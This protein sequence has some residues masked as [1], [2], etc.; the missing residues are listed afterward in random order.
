MIQASPVEGEQVRA[1]E[2]ARRSNPEVARA[3]EESESTYAGLGGKAAESLVN[4][5]DPNL[6]DEPAGG[7]PTLPE[8]NQI[9][10]FPT[11]FAMSVAGSGGSRE[12][13]E[14]LEP[15]AF[16]ATPG[17]RTAIDLGLSEV[18]G[19]Y[20]PKAGLA[21]VRI[22]KRLNEGAALSEAGVSLTPVDEQGVA[23]AGEGVLDGASVFYGDTEDAS[24]GIMDVDTLVKPSTFGL[25]METILRSQR[26]PSRLFFKVGL[27]EEA[28]LEQESAGSGPVHVVDNGRTLAVIFAPSARDA[29]GT[30]V[31]VSMVVDGD[32]LVLTVDHPAGAYAYPI[33]VDP[34]YEYYAS[35]FTWDKQVN[36]SGSHATNWHFE[37]EGSL[38][39]GSE[40]SSGQG[41]IMHIAGNH[42]EHERGWMAYTTNG[43]SH[44]W[45]FASET[46]QRESE[47]RVESRVELDNKSGVESEQV[48]SNEVNEP[49]VNTPPYCRMGAKCGV[50]PEYNNSAAYVALAS[51]A[52]TGNAGENVFHSA[53]VAVQQ[54]VNPEVSFDTTDATVDGHPNAL[55][56]TKTWLG[57]H[58]NA[59]VKFTASEKGIGIEGWSSEHTNSKGGWEHLSEKSMLT[60][61]LCSG[62]QCPSEETEYIGYTS[63][64][65]DGEP[66]LGLDAWNAMYDSH[67]K[68][69]ESESLRH[70]VVK[71]DS[72]PPHSLVLTGLLAGNEIGAGE[73]HLK[74]E[75]TDGSGTTP[76]SGV[77]SIALQIDGKEVKSPSGF[78]EPGPCTAKSAEWTIIGR[79]YA[80]GR[81]TLALIATDNA[82]NVA[83][84]EDITMTVR[85]A[86][87][88]SLG[89]GSVNLESGE[90]TLGATDVSMG[91]LT[92]SR[93]YG[94]RHL[95]AGAEGP[96]G[97][98][99]AIS[100]TGQERLEKQA[101]ESVIFTN[102][103]GA[104]DIFRSKSK[105]VFEA[106]PGDS[107]L[108]LTESESEGAKTY[109]LANAASDTKTV[110]TLPEGGG[111]AWMPKIQEGP[112]PTD[113]VTYTFKTETEEG[114]KIT[115]PV[116]ALAPVPANVS[117]SPTLK[118]GCR[119]LEFIYG[120]ETKATGENESEW[121]EYKGRLKEV[122]FVA[123]NPATKK[124]EPK[125]VAAYAY[126]KQGRLR[127]EWD[128]RLEHP[129][130]VVYGYDAE[131][132]VTALTPPGQESWALI[133]GTIAGDSTA[134]RLLKV[135]QAPASAGLWDGEPPKNT[136]APKLTGTA[137]PSARMTV[138]N[139]TWSNA[140]V[141]YGYQWEDCNSAGN[142][143][144]PVLG[145]T[146]ANY[147]VASSDVGHRL[148]AQVTGANGGGSVVAATAASLE[149]KAAGIE[150]TEYPLAKETEPK[151]IA[152]GPDGNLWIAQAKST[153]PTVSKMTT[154]GKVTEYKLTSPFECPEY[155][156]A[157]PA[158]EAALWF[159]DNC[160][161]QIGK[162]T[163]SGTVK[164]Y[165]FTAGVG[166]QAITAGPDGNLWFTMTGV[167][168][169]GKITPAGT[170]SEYSAPSGSEP[171]VIAAG[172]EKES[173][174][175]FTDFKTSKIGK[176]TTSG[177]ITEYSLP[178]GS[179]PYGITAGPENEKA[180]WF[181]DWGTSK[182][183][184]ITTSGTITEYPIPS[185]S[186]SR[187][188]AVGPEGEKALWF[189]DA[190]TSKIGRITTSG[191]VTED[192][193]PSESRPQKI[194]AGPEKEQ[195]VWFSEEGPSKV[196]KVT[197]GPSTE[198]EQQTPRPGST[199]EYNV[200]LSGSG[201]PTMTK[202]EVEKWGQADD[203]AEATA[204]FPPDE[205]QGWPASGYKR[206]TIYY[207]D[208]KGRTVNVRSPS[209]GISTSEYNENNDAV[210]SLTPDN[211]AAALAEGSK[212][213]EVAKLL[214][215]ESKY[216][217]ET[218][219][220][221]EKEEKEP[222]SAAG[223]RL[224]E[225]LGPRHA[226]RLPHGKT[227]ENEEV[228]ARNHTVYYY[229]EGAPSE[230]GP[231]RLVTKV[232]QGAQVNG[233]ADR[234][235][236]TTTDSYS[237]QEGLGWKLRAPT[238]VTG[239]PSGLKVTHTTVYE[240]S[241]GNV[242]ETRAPAS[243]GEGN[244]HDTR[245]IYYTAAEN[246]S[247]PGCGEQPQWAEMPCETLPGKQPEPAVPVITTTYNMWGE[248]EKITRTVGAVTRT[249]TVE[250][251]GAGRPLASEAI[252]SEGKALPKVK[253]EYNAETGALEKQS[254]TTEGETKTITSKDNAR[255]QLV[256]YTDADGNTTEYEYELEK[257]GRL[258]RVNDGKGTQ[259][260]TYEETTGAVSKLVDTQG[261]NVLTFTAAYDVEG[262]MAS[263]GYPNGMTASDSR[264][265][266][267]ETTGLT[268]E[269]KTHCTEKCVWFTESVTPSIHDQTLEQVNSLTKNSYTYDEAG[270]LTQVQ[271]TP[272]GEGCTTRIYEND[273][274]GN[275]TKLTT[276]PPGTGGVCAA[277]GG[278]T[279]THTYDSANRLT[280]TGVVYDTF[281]DITK[282]PATDAGGTELQSTFYVDGQLDEQKQGEQTIGYQLD[283]SGRTR[284][285][286]DTG[287]V[288]STY[289][290]HYAGP[291][292]SPAW[293]V[294]PTSGHWTRYV[295]GIGGFA[296]IETDTT[297]PELQLTNLQGDVV[298]RASASETATKLLST[299]RSTEYG[300]P[301]TTKPGKYSWLGG[302]LL[303]T[304][305]PSGAVAMGVRSYVPQI[306]R[307]LQPDPIPGGSANAYAYTDGNPV[308]ETD[309]TGGYVENNYLGGIF[310]GQN[311][312]AIEMEA[313]REAAA[314]AEAER[315]A[316]EAAW[317]AAGAA[318]MAAEL[319]EAEA[320][321][322]WD[323]EAAA[324]PPGAIPGGGM[325][326]E[327]EESGGGDP[328][329]RAASV[330]PGFA[331]ALKAF[332]PYSSGNHH[333]AGT[334]KNE[335]TGGPV[336]YQDA[337]ACLEVE[338]HNGSFGKVDCTSGS[339]IGLGYIPLY[340]SAPCNGTFAWRVSV[341]GHA[342]VNGVLYG[343]AQKSAV[344]LLQCL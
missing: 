248:P 182:V 232:T 239:D 158:K 122:L 108:T 188:I 47:T 262:N 154:A 101:E 152:V 42:G 133:Y 292:D 115:R 149:V 287:T 21:P 276:R 209:G 211:R 160:D 331:C 310:A 129:L 3:R 4:G 169:I 23:L 40:A 313:A 190:G 302:D 179:E 83:P 33:T 132:H 224:L 144:T 203:P 13:R 66:T 181:T 250:Y 252:S 7:P 102:S 163:T 139:G 231:Y 27:P 141:A 223:T 162:I 150:T 289:I 307:F 63:A 337:G 263:E 191:T 128:P 88:A 230:G 136:A 249:T 100:L 283:P 327:G 112:V 332:T 15:V 104:Q 222:N 170:V 166:L 245:I 71:V 72:T 312:E 301:T 242:T 330:A 24:A 343:A 240:A 259:E 65:P 22:A 92:V 5:S 121:G 175:W 195:S 105:G 19:A 205:A 74:A 200:P 79:N 197:T 17:E 256:K 201:L 207:Q 342:E 298:A 288:N 134:G 109:I 116:E 241:T 323:A 204:I 26:S 328:V 216:N 281:G 268:Y 55:Y 10:G 269:K 49:A 37:H 270:G 145:A 199:I 178:S 308:N 290:S 48:L 326:E 76:S 237:G 25:M 38:F 210:R 99:W 82:G 52:G 311:Q 41:W 103:T 44:I 273:E 299:E 303:P 147:T 286:V 43:L 274:E 6:V 56:G 215:T 214:S 278:S 235:V 90:F 261:S 138:S 284:E 258:T 30:L 123:N 267:G 233:E 255:G 142:G 80:V 157:G 260:Y 8:G 226:V 77:K 57:P 293:I 84:P 165:N 78:C 148:V 324:G 118:A 275:R 187:S 114:K 314:R 106:P 135:T 325:E 91:G 316:Q 68:E 265:A 228:E 1:V 225:T 86:G 20:Q 113:T 253:N 146:N 282:L 130:K 34:R 16:E 198:G 266:A 62:I 45:D 117:C 173:A 218:K 93:S 280:D 309:V 196:G 31:P 137:F 159:V 317:A 54:E 306:G 67:A 29:E 217:G 315:E 64:L 9:L 143:C 50:T 131:G 87:S 339:K 98:Q 244:A 295:S 177:A 107:N 234:D 212:S 36:K 221:K 35:E 61:G 220:E 164:A 305:L 156:A 120:K 155:I 279:Q 81:H 53:E 73:Y 320:R 202:A 172:P 96:L 344:K 336:A 95:A 60:E 168:K 171:Q 97:S 272:A 247:Y 251:D 334:A 246:K 229:D 294:E 238:S 75:A 304:E 58:T 89:P 127:A 32:T 51:G 85:P 46:A 167:S 69:N 285:T 110:F 124:V 243:G 277:E 271:E 18:N 206:A 161:H 254:V 329:A 236:R 176:I 319:A 321:N 296:A 153:A 184:K 297:E 151:G 213:A 291:G 180:L 208:A 94:S 14:G 338:H 322:T 192:S 193:L 189:A 300:V 126:D 335:C 174:L 219:E 333:I 140:P 12:V 340:V 119:A 186:E 341:N 59:L 125:A 185:G 2:E 264:N 70:H 28:T 39:T 227:K 257:D 111:S 194:T 318:K 11:D 183:G